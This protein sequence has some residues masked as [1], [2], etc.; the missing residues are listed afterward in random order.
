[1]N[2][3]DKEYFECFVED[4]IPVTIS[5][6]FLFVMMG[7]LIVIWGK[8]PPR[9]PAQLAGSVFFLIN[10]FTGI[11][12]IKKKRTAA[13]L[14]TVRRGKSAVIEG[15]LWIIFCVLG[16]LSALWLAIESILNN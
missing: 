14:F 8:D 10:S 15:S 7:L 13:P 16:A 4:S 11:T 6:V 1:M 9:I 5:F 3:R 2:R 12:I